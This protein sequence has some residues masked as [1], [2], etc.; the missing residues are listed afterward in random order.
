MCPSGGQSGADKTATKE[1]A[2]TKI[3]A[4]VCGKYLL[5]KLIIGPILLWYFEG[6][7]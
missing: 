7:Q 6:A 3:V 1:Q 4:K 5:V 2:T